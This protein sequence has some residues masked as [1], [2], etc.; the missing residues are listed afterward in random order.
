LFFSALRE[1]IG[2][3]EMDLVLT[4][5][6]TPDAL[7]KQLVDKMPEMSAFATVIRLAVNQVYADEETV[8]RP[9]DEVAI[10]TPVSGG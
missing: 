4:S 3:R 8:I 7:I 1:K 5:T 6:T 9:G 10:L 2:V